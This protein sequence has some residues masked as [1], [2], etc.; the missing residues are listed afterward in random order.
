ME[1][2]KCKIIQKEIEQEKI[3]KLKNQIWLTRMSRINAEKRML[4]NENFVQGINIYYSCVITLASICLLRW[5][6]SNLDLLVTFM[7]VALLVVILYL[8]SLRFSERALDFHK[9][10]PKLQKLEFRLEKKGITDIEIEEIKDQY[11]ELM[12]KGENHITYD[13]YK[14]IYDSTG[15]YRE[16]NC[17][18][19]I[20]CGYCWGYFWRALIMVMVVL[21]PSLITL[22]FLLLML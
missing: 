8:K 7:S 18:T 22:P 17:T 9:L 20:K 3:S 14:A 11:S 15:D 12:A 4:H 16:K 2:A 21:F 6:E 1:E 13:Y 10:Y 5:K 19:I